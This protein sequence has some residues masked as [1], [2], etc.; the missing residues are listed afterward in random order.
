[1]VKAIAA[2]EWVRCGLYNRK[3]RRSLK[4]DSAASYLTVAAGSFLFVVAVFVG[5]VVLKS[6]N[7]DFWLARPFPDG[8]LSYRAY[9]NYPHPEIQDRDVFFH[10]IG[11]LITEARKA[12]IIILG[13]SVWLY[14]LDDEQVRAFNLKHGVRLF[15][16]ASAGTSSGNFVRAVIKRWDIHPRLWIINADDE[17]VSFFHPDIDDD[18][19]TGSAN[20]INIVQTPRWKGFEHAFIRNLRW[21]LGDLIGYLPEGMGDRFFPAFAKRFQTWRSI[22]TGDWLFA[23]GGYYDVF[24]NA[25]FSPPPRVCPLSD[26]EISWARE[27]VADIGSRVILTMVP[28]ARWCPQRVN[29]LAHALGVEALPQASTEYSNLDGRHMDRRGAKA[30][31]AWFLSAL[32]KTDAFAA[33]IKHV[34]VRQ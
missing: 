10:D 20:A 25:R 4:L 24:Y 27:F 18:A 7:A 26:A 3:M 34:S 21:R 33:I 2:L 29:D 22:E 1:M 8:P 32:E 6:W 31:T 15:N 9:N 19:A 14:A 17:T 16:M 30:Y 11:G 28:Y 23:P 13:H 12:D 5:Y